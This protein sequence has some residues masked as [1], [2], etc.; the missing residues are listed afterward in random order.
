MDTSVQKWGN[1]LA[2]R[3]PGALAKDI[4]LTQ[5]MRVDLSVFRGNLIVKPKKRTKPSLEKMLKVITKKNLPDDSDFGV[6][7]GKEIW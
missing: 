5:G 2:L 3:V 4:H 1:S 7:V 6:P